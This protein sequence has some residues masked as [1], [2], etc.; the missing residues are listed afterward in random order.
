RV[1]A[2]IAGARGLGPAPDAALLAELAADLAADEEELAPAPA[3]PGAHAQE[4]IDLLAAVRAA[5]AAAT[6]YQVKKLV[7]ARGGKSWSP[8]ALPPALAA[9]VGDGLVSRGEGRP[10][11]YRLTEA[12]AELLALAEQRERALAAERDAQAAMREAQAAIAVRLRPLAG[13]I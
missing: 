5:G 2:V 7:A 1:E 13:E 9:L 6:A 8:A 3:D 12:G 11:S 4:L 10:A